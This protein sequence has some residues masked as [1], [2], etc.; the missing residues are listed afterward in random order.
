MD[1][2]REFS[3]PVFFRLSFKMLGEMEPE[4]EKEPVSWRVHSKRMK[5]VVPVPETMKP[6]MPKMMTMEP[7]IRKELHPVYSG[8]SM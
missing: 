7:V 6:V 8:I 2:E 4:T 3:P 5:S 1:R